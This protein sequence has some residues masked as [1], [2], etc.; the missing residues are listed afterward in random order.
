MAGGV[1]CGSSSHLIAQACY[2]VQV[3]D[4][5]PFI[6]HP[7][8]LS[9]VQRSENEAPPACVNSRN[10]PSL[11][12]LGLTYPDLFGG[13]VM[14]PPAKRSG[15]LPDEV[16]AGMTAILVKRSHSL[17]CGFHSGCTLVIPSRRVA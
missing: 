12:N 10:V 9:V 4:E 14:P 13:P 15:C 7:S 11:S 16:A 1:A 8:A 3:Y 2:L 17:S 6:A 5:D